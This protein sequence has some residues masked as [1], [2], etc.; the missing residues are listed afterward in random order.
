[1]KKIFLSLLTAAMLPLMSN[2]A[3]GW[4]ANY[5][6]VMLQGFSWDNYVDTQWSNMEKQ[7][8][9]LSSTFD[10]IWV[11]QS[12]NC[13]TGWN[14]MG[15][16][17]V[18]WFNHNSSFGTERALRS[19]ISA[20]KAK[21]T[22]IIEDVVINHRSSLGE[23]GSWV[24]FP[25]EVY[26]GT[27]YQLLPTDVCADDDGGKTKTWATQHGISLSTNN[28]TGEG[29]DGCRDLDHKSTNVRNN[30]KAYLNFL[31]ND[32][33]YAGFRYDMVRGYSASYTGEYNASANPTF[34]VGELWDGNV[35]TLQNWLN[36]T[37]VNNVIQS[38]CFD[39]A[40]RYTVRDA[41]NQNNWTKVGNTSLAR[42]ANYR[43][44]A[45]TFVENH[46]MQDRGNVTNY[47][48]DPIKKDTL[49]ANAFLLAM[50]GTPC[51][52]LTHWKAYKK[53]IKS[54]VEARKLAGVTNMS[55]TAPFRSSTTYY[56]A[57]TT[58]SRG[59]LLAVVG[60]TSI[61]T[62]P[63]TT[64]V[65]ILSG[66][67][68]SYFL[69]KDVESAWIDVP[70]G[71]YETAFPVKLIAVSNSATQLVYTLDGSTP[72][73]S[74]PKV[75]SGASINITQDCTLTVGLLSGSNVTGIMK[76]EYKIQ[77]FEPHTA[78]VYLKAPGWKDVYFYSWDK[79]NVQLLGNWPGT[80]Q[81]EY[82]YINGTKFYYHTFDIPTSD[83]Y[84]NIIFDQGDQS[85]DPDL[86]QT[87]DIG[88]INQDVYY[89]IAELV[90]GKYTVNDITSQYEG[91]TVG[92][93]GDVNGDGKVNVSDVSALI[94]MILGLSAMDQ[95][96]GDVN[97]DGRVNVSDVS[98]L[99]NII[100]GI[101]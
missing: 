37:K 29:W 42:N 15:Y 76:H 13:N 53:E 75:N 59:K 89:E 50:P 99:I 98:A 56:A 90:N 9:E 4:P 8:D 72:K 84:F 14:V 86:K 30:V 97:G 20:F 43:Q 17:P 80:K 18:Y 45:V 12:G 1:M 73:A 54:M 41:I 19:M 74:S 16:M 62:N 88:P 65:N 35:N 92:L 60:N 87:V 39:F 44:F 96:A 31:L 47:T 63:G 28:D 40:F 79:G 83:Y 26:N 82:K 7:V 77:P 27:T 22:S 70:S 21:G 10:I 81:T 68:Y 25:A 100:L 93:P 38:A 24:D 34:S 36:A 58:G 23:D 85:V 33:G 2:A 101:A 64:W 55:N 95:S 11:P 5:G 94:N 48:P 61:L 67:H 51:V 49:A 69:S 71:T 46:D 52:F 91:G 57:N 32:L 3:V 78:T 6:G 66:Y